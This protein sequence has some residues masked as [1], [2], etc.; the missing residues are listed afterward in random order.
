MSLFILTGLF[1]CLYFQEFICAYYLH[2]GWWEVHALRYTT[3]IFCTLI[4]NT[5]P[6][7]YT[8]SWAVGEQT[9]S[10]SLCNQENRGHHPACRPHRFGFWEPE[11]LNVSTVWML[12][13]LSSW[14]WWS[15]VSS[16]DIQKSLFF[17]FLL[18]VTWSELHVSP[19]V[20]P[21]TLVGLASCSPKLK[22]LCWIHLYSHCS[23]IKYRKPSYC[24]EWTVY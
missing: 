24:A 19:L 14:E 1:V 18:Q 13:F 3:S 17:F 21:D 8:L 15:R 10:D 23:I 20:E 22:P 7:I 12:L 2:K 11:T 5:V 9:R 4:F 16:T 6:N